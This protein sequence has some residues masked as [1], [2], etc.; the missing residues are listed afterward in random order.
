[1]KGRYDR[2]SAFVVAEA[3]FWHVG[4]W[5]LALAA[6]IVQVLVWDMVRGLFG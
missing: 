3:L 6:F 1:M 2:L 4:G 5:E